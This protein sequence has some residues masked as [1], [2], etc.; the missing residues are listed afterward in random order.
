MSKLSARFSYSL[1]YESQ[2]L[3]GS[4]GTDTVTRASVVYDF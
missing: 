4:V 3:P 1:R 2:P